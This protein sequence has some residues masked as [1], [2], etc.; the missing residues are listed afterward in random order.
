MIEI[1]PAC[2]GMNFT[3]CDN[4]RHLAEKIEKIRDTGTRCLIRGGLWGENY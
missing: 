4:Y 1:S 3:G 2:G